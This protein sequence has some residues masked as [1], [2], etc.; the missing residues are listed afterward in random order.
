M[1]GRDHIQHHARRAELRTFSIIAGL[2]LSF[3]STQIKAHESSVDWLFDVDVDLATVGRETPVSVEI[4]DKVRDGCWLTASATEAKVKRELIEAGFSKISDDFSFDGIHMDI[5][6]LGF[7]TGSYSCAAASVITI[8]TTSIATREVEFGEHEWLSVD[9][10]IIYN[11]S[12]ILG[13]PKSSMSSRINSKIES[14]VDDFIVTLHQEKQ[15]LFDQVSETKTEDVYKA[16]LLN[17][18]APLKQ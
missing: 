18:A 10:K 4:S 11:N 6:V 15:A 7:E 1:A 16:P 2:I 9:Y 17:A 3:A 8:L 13:G 5:Q 12:S 14:Y